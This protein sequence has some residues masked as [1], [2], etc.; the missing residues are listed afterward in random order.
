MAA[1]SP[2]LAR[3]RHRADEEE[4]TGDTLGANLVSVHCL[5]STAADPIVHTTNQ[6]FLMNYVGSVCEL[7]AL[8]PFQR[9]WKS[10]VENCLL[11]ILWNCFSRDCFAIEIGIMVIFN[12]E[13]VKIFFK[14]KLEN[15][16]P[17]TNNI[18]LEL[19]SRDLEYSVIPG[20]C[21]SL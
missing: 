17:S 21:L 5:F 9:C 13:S 7:M 10:F 2:M 3:R 1:Y 12:L 8:L 20:T 18:L 11:E 4:D 14:T 6:C 19:L 16:T 15:I